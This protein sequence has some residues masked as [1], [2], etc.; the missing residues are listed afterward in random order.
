MCAPL[1][2][3][4]AAE[5]WVAPLRPKAGHA[6]ARK[7]RLASLIVCFLEC[8]LPSVASEDTLSRVGALRRSMKP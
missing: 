3:T 5:A 6:F 1:R 4:G 2:T 7:P 8:R